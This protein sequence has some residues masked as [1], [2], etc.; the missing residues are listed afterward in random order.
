MTPK[1]RHVNCARDTLRSDFYEPQKNEIYFLNN[2]PTIKS[3]RII[4]LQLAKRTL[5]NKNPYDLSS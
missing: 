2:Q 4:Q 1:G 3:S 5:L